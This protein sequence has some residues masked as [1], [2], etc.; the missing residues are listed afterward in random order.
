MLAGVALFINREF[1]RATVVSKR[2]EK[3]IVV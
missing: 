3:S 1:A 2:W